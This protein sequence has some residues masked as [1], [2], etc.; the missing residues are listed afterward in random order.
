MKVKPKILLSLADKIFEVYHRGKKSGRV[1]QIF[2]TKKDL[3]P[4]ISNVPY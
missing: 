4:V 3:R 1:R 2:K